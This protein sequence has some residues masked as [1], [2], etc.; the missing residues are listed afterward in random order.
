ML[1]NYASYLR[2][3][4]A[5]AQI[6]RKTLGYE[7][8]KNWVDEN[9]DSRYQKAK[10]TDDGTPTEEII[11]SKAGFLQSFEHGYNQGKRGLYKA[12]QE[13]TSGP[14]AK[15]IVKVLANL[16]R[17]VG[18]FGESDGEALKSS[19]ALASTTAFRRT[20]RD[21]IVGFPYLTQG[22]LI[23][24]ME[25]DSYFLCVMPKCDTAR[26]TKPRKFLFAKLEC[27]EG[28]F[29]LVAPDI[30]TDGA[31]VHLQTNF[32]FYNLE[33]F[34]FKAKN[35]PKVEAFGEHGVVVFESE[36]GAKYQ[37][38]GDLEDLDAQTKVSSIVGDFN[39]VGVDEIEWVRRR[40]N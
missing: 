26:V 31:Y 40:K 10:I 37:W 16:E 25:D 12:I 6:D 36:A 17:I 1:E 32:K 5:L 21:L 24:S 22:T 28:V 19:Q 7:I 35:G 8:I 30:A 4:L 14:R 27:N 13:P 3:I 38:I 39:R 20:F 18:A 34:E 33:H 29:D 23:K 11:L 2:N 15:K 9:Y